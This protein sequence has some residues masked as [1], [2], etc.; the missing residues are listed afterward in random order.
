MVHTFGGAR[1]ESIVYPPC[2]S[3]TELEVGDLVWW[4]SA[5]N[6]AKPLSGQVDNTSEERNQAEAAQ[7]FLGRVTVPSP[8]GVTVVGVD[9]GES[10]LVHEVTVPS[11]TYRFGSLL[12]PSENG[13]GN[14]LEDQQLE[15]VTSRD[16]ATHVVLDDSSSARE[17]VLASPIRSVALPSPAL[18]S[19]VN[20]EALSGNKALTHNDTR[21][22][23]LDPGGSARDLTLPAEEESAG[24][25][26]LIFNTADA[27]EA[28]T[29]KDDGG[30]TV[31]TI[32]QNEGAFLACDG[33]AW[34][35][36]AGY[37]ATP[38]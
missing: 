21:M 22:Q 29:V 17:T 23:F 3:A 11:G 38:T 30:A 33:T 14:G 19:Q 10:R 8:D 15:A 32:A 13:D 28:I 35:G 26:F 31:L 9:L 25:E 7:G 16:L 37:T 20:S 12:G 24:L 34:R 18:R 5:N 27:A 1:M 2:E 6:L 36:F 4:D